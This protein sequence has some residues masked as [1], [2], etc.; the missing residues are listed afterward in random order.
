MKSI[1]VF[2]HNHNSFD[3]KLL[4]K[5]APNQFVNKSNIKVGEFIKDTDVLQFFMKDIDELLESYEPGKPQHKPD[6]LK[7]MNEIKE[8]R[9]RAINEHK[10]KLN[11]N[12]LN[13]NNDTNTS[14]NSNKVNEMTM[15]LNELL[16]EN[17]QLKD[18]VKYLEDKITKI[19][20]QQIEERKKQKQQTK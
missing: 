9:E 3:K 13:S 7:Q 4:L 17:N 18:K 5:D 15:I 19:I 20:A 10:Q 11:A 1:L 12:L 16:M 8:R 6:V 14:A 2:S